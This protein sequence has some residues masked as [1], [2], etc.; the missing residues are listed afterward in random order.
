MY[1]NGLKKVNLNIWIYTLLLKE[2]I[3]NKL[4]IKLEQIFFVN[5]GVTL[6]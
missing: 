6:T 2:K 5:M 4:G 3:Y 1:Y